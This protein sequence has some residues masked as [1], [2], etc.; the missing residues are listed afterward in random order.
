[1]GHD[2]ERPSSRGFPCLDVERRRA[3]VLVAD[4]VRD[5]GKGAS[6]F[7]PMLILVCL[8]SHGLIFRSS[9]PAARRAVSRYERRLAFGTSNRRPGFVGHTRSRASRAAGL[10][11][12]QRSKPSL[13]ISREMKRRFAPFV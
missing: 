2:I 1:L 4:E 10:R 6:L 11:G 13:S 3:D 8:K 9:R 12:I 5:A 7:A